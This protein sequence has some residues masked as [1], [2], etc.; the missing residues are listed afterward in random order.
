[1]MVPE[2]LTEKAQRFAREYE[3]DLNY[4]TQLALSEKLPL[5]ERA[6]AEGIKPKLAAFTILSTVTE[7]RREGVAVE[8]IA[9]EDY[10][11]TWHAVESGK[12]AKEGIPDLLRGLASGDSFDAVIRKLVPA[13]S[14]QELETLIHTIVT[15]R[16]EFVEQKGKAALG[17]L[18]GLVMTEVRGSV[19]GKIVSELLNKEIEAALGRKKR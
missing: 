4:A 17:P 12:A 2:L 11:A 5:F 14:R 15:D 8:K 3:I 13:I 9:D 6:L 16:S 10:L 18:M 7:L 19:D 1:V